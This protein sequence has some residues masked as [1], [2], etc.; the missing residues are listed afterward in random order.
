[1][2]ISLKYV[3]QI[4][5]AQQRIFR[6]V[7]NQQ[8]GGRYLHVCFYSSEYTL[9]RLYWKYALDYVS[10]ELII[11]SIQSIIKV[12]LRLVLH[13]REYARKCIKKIFSLLMGKYLKYTSGPFLKFVSQNHSVTHTPSALRLSFPINIG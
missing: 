13:I 10:V 4:H 8:A 9:Y 2:G 11:K 5:L 1:M 12:N 7:L 6:L 3:K